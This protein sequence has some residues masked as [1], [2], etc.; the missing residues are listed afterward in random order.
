MA[1]AS[2]TPAEAP[3]ACTTRQPI[4]VQALPASAQPAEPMMNSTRPI[5]IGRRRP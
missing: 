1:R 3:T 2:T 5:A 4:I